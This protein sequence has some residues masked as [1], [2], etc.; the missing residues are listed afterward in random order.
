MSLGGATGFMQPGGNSAPLDQS[1]IPYL[2]YAQQGPYQAIMSQMGNY[3]AGAG[4]F[5]GGTSG[6]AMGGFNPDLYKRAPAAAPVIADIKSGSGTRGGGSRDRGEASGDYGARSFNYDPNS[7]TGGLL[8]FLLGEQT[9]APIVDT[10][11][12]S[13]V[14][15]AEAAQPGIN[16]GVISQPN[17]ISG[18]S[19]NPNSLLG[20]AAGSNI[21][22]ISQP[23][24]ISGYSVGPAAPAVSDGGFNPISGYSLAPAPVAVAQPVTYSPITSNDI[25]SN[26][27]YSNDGYGGRGGGYGGGDGGG[28]AATGGRDGDA[29][30]GGDRG[31]RGGFAKGGHVSMQHLQGPNPMGP[32]DGYGALKSG[33]F[34]IND[35]A[36]KKY[37][38]ELMNAINSGKISKGKLRGLLEM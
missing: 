8:R 37:G 12:F 16:S 21:G 26:D 17:P 24:P 33:E 4:N 38:I 25:P 13:S 23:N 36:V 7:Y 11:G 5:Y 19:L 35:K 3:G 32:D 29:S 6:G 9:P 18:Y 22:T 15:E 20:T 27:N 2:P 28:G 14:A 34:V 31:T 10:S 1:T 30:G